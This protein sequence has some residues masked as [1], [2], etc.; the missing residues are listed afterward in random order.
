MIEVRYTCGT[1]SQE[2]WSFSMPYRERDEEIVEWLETKVMEALRADHDRRSPFC[3]PE[4]IQQ[5][6]FPIPKGDGWVGGP[7]IQ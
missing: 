1:C 2:E 4:K 5:I 6:K 7:D 3:R